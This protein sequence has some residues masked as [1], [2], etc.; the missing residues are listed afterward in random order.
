MFCRV[1]CQVD[2]IYFTV[3]CFTL[4]WILELFPGFMITN[5]AAL[6]LLVH[7]SLC[8]YANICIG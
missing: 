4:W 7:P 8:I 1:P 3:Y 5:K 2:F 6:N